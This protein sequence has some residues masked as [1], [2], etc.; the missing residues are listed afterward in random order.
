ML[1]SDYE[2][3]HK[4]FCIK[5]YKNTQDS[6]FP[7]LSDFQQSETDSK[8]AC[9]EILTQQGLSAIQAA[10]FLWLLVFLGT[11]LYLINL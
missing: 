2:Q 11:D 8:G 7:E 3:N 4:I 9:G 1:L 10:F 6:K 5:E